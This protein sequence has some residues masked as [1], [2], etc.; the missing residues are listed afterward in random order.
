MA[1]DSSREKA[2]SIDELK[3][4][5]AQLHASPEATRDE[6]NPDAD[7]PKRNPMEDPEYS[8][9]FE[10]KTRRGELYTGGFVNRIL[11][12]G[13]Q[14]EVATLKARLS[15]G[16]PYDSLSPDI[17]SLNE[18]IAHMTY[19]FWSA[20]GDDFRGPN[21]A[22]DLRKLRDA[23]VIVALWDT[24]VAHERCFFRHDE[25]SEESTSTSE[26]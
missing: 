13:E 18:A 1:N 17:R 10:N 8:F 20:D 11:N 4:E 6:Q 15:G 22:R 2:R 19:S 7:P 3:A 23:E 25:D 21:W 9:R 14:Q 26:D 5:V 24:V 16:V 12:I